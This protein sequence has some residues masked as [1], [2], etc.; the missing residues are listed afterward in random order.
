MS[1]ARGSWP[2]LLAGLLLSCAD[3]GSASAESVGSPTDGSTS[4]AEPTGPGEG[5]TGGDSSVRCEDGLWSGGEDG[6]EDTGFGMGDDMPL[7]LT[8]YEVQQGD[9]PDRALVGIA[10]VVVTTPAA[11]SELL[12]CTELFVQELAGG[13]YSGL[14][15]QAEGFDPSTVLAVGDTVDIV[16]RLSRSGDYVLLEVRNGDDLS[17]TGTA[18]LPEPV[19]V[20]AAALGWADPTARPYEGVMVRVQMATVTDDD[21][22]DGEFELEDTVRVDDRFVPSA[23]P[24]PAQGEVLGAVEG[25]LVYASDGYELAPPDGSLVE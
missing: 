18:P 22:C 9:G 5:P 4:V 7:P 6:A 25:V 19:V 23:L 1:I 10:N 20:E 24:S 21:P 12:P 2:A 15:I 3:D 13:A 14:R 11:Q 8:V 17:V 16:G